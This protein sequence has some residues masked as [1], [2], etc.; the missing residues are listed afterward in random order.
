A[1][2]SMTMRYPSLGMAMDG[3]VRRQMDH[4]DRE[5]D[6]PKALLTGVDARPL[7]N[8]ATIKQH[9][10]SCRATV[11]MRRDIQYYVC[12]RTNRP[13]KA[14]AATSPLAVIPSSAAD[15]FGLPWL[16]AA[17]AGRQIFG[18]R[19]PALGPASKAHA[20][21]IAYFAIL[22]TL[23][24]RH[25]ERCDGAQGEQSPVGI[26]HAHFA[27]KGLCAPFAG[28]GINPL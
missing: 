21:A 6:D 17:L 28:I 15:A 9:C 8:A 27:S 26:R 7:R 10:R 25:I 22:L 14:P 20:Q 3:A 18:S 11:H 24:G 5:L 4:H 23:L 16:N 19:L 1:N 2:C 13:T 12:A